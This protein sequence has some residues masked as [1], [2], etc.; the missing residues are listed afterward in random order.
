MNVAVPPPEPVA[1]SSMLLSPPWP[2][3]QRLRC[4][5][6][7]WLRSQGASPFSSAPLPRSCL[8]STTKLIRAHPPLS[9]SATVG[10]HRY[11]GTSEGGAFTMYIYIY[12]YISAIHTYIY[13]YYIY[14]YVDT[15]VYA[16][17]IILQAA[18]GKWLLWVTP[19]FCFLLGGLRGAGLPA[20]ARQ[21]P[22]GAALSG[23]FFGVQR[24]GGWHRNPRRTPGA[25]FFFCF[26]VLLYGQPH[27]LENKMQ[28]PQWSSFCFVFVI[29]NLTNWNPTTSANTGPLIFRMGFLNHL[30]GQ[31]IWE[32]GR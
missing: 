2:I 11:T 29:D 27:Q 1:P 6:Q 7:N 31:R 24:P 21:A 13:I 4:Q 30:E 15:H 5:Y 9:L 18:C 26:F 28:F 32:V 22:R 23:R 3:D 12:I 19:A 25:F 20:G 17:C 16:V 10:P 14:I 8:A